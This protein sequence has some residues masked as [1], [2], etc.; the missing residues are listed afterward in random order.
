MKNFGVAE[1]V[2]VN[3]CIIGAEAR[4]RAMR[5]VDVLDA[6][7]TVADLE[8]ALK[9]TDLVVGTSGIDTESEKRFAR[10]SVTPWDFA[11]R[12]AKTQRRVALLFGREDFGLLD[13]ELLRCD[14][15][16]TIPASPDY[17][18]LNLSH[19][20]T[21]RSLR[22]SDAETPVRL[23][24]ALAAV[25]LELGQGPNRVDVLGYDVRL[26]MDGL[27]VVQPLAVDDM[28]AAP[29]DGDLIQVRAAPGEVPGDFHDLG[30]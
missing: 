13:R 19:P 5:A 20:V 29:P 4:K 9:D 25:V 6:A 27:E 7:R 23:F 26:L 11:T 16:V 15:C 17:P 1:L 24:H 8:R 18:M 3:P 12:V 10:I 22:D 21:L 30:G 28:D 2:L 14:L